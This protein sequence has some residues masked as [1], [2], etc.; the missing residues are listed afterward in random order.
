MKINPYYIAAAVGI[1]GN[2]SSKGLGY[3]FSFKQLN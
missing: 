2:A 1:S 3:E